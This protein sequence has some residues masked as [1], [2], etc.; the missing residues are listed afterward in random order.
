MF[1]KYTKNITALKKNITLI[2]IT[3]A[4]VLCFIALRAVFTFVL[5]ALATGSFFKR[6][7][8]FYAISYFPTWYIVAFYIITVLISIPSVNDALLRVVTKGNS[9]LD[10]SFPRK[11][12]KWLIL[13]AS[14]ASIAVF[15]VF[16]VKYGFLGNNYLRVVNI[17]HGQFY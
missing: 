17:E 16:R 15:W 1:P 13:L 14:I 12:R 2:R 11:R 5:P 9:W 7:W 3:G 10:R 4:A 6:T 8:G